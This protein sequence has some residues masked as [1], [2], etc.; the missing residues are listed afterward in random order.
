MPFEAF[1]TLQGLKTLPA[2]M[3]IHCENALVIAKWLEAHP[4][5]DRVYYP[6]LSAFPQY[7]LASRQQKGPGGMLSFELKASPEDSLAVMNALKLCTRAE[8]LGSVETLITHPASATHGDIPK[9][10]RDRLGITD[11]LIRLSVGLEAPEDIIADLD[12]ALTSVLRAN[13][14]AGGAR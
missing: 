8:S 4:A 9:E 3:K 7:E 5:V 2:R 12:Q 14:I 11:R 1:L 13:A 10:E 6:G